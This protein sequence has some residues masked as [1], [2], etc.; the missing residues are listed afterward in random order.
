PH[1]E[2]PDKLVFHWYEMCDA[3]QDE[4]YEIDGVEVSNFVLPLYFTV[5]EQV[6]SRNDF[7]NRS[8]D[9]QTLPSFGVNP[10]G[11]VGFFDPEKGDHEIFAPGR[12]AQARKE[13]KQHAYARRGDVFARRAQM[14]LNLTSR[15]A[16]R[17]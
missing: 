9:G 4:S 7:L 15:A 2:C 1:P 10:G 14:Y 16:R 11:Y 17:G 8:Y 3:V 6:G 13:T 5:G 12:R